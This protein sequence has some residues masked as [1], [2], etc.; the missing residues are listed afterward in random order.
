MADTPKRVI[1][2]IDNIKLELYEGS[3]KKY[4]QIWDPTGNN[5]YN[6]GDGGPSGIKS[7]ERSKKYQ[8]AE[9]D[10]DIIHNFI[11][12]YSQIVGYYYGKSNRSAR[13][14]YFNY[15]QDPFSETPPPKRIY[16]GGGLGTPELDNVGPTPYYLNN[17][18][19]V[20][21]KWTGRV[22]NPEFKLGTFS[23][24]DEAEDYNQSL[25]PEGPPRWLYDQPILSDMDETD[26]TENPTLRPQSEWILK[27]YYN[28]G[29]NVTPGKTYSDYRDKPFVNDKFVSVTLPTGF[30]EN[31]GKGYL[32]WIGSGEGKGL[33]YSTVPKG[34][35]SYVTAINGRGEGITEESNNSV[36]NNF[37]DYYKDEDILKT[38]INGYQGQVSSL[39]KTSMYDYALKVC[40]PDTGT[41]SP[42]PYKSPIVDL[43][44]VG[45]T[46][47]VDVVGAT[48]SLIPKK[49]KLNVFGLPG[50]TSLSGETDGNIKVK[51][52]VSLP[53]FTVYLGDPPGSTG[54][55]A[56]G[57]N[58]FGLIDD[59]VENPDPY[60]E[61]P[62]VGPVDGGERAIP[63][64]TQDEQTND[65]KQQEE[66]A[67]KQN[68]EEATASDTQKLPDG[69]K[70]LGTYYSEFPADS[71]KGGE[72]PSGFNGVPYYQQFDIRWANV[73]YG[74][75]DGGTFV[76]AKI[77]PRL[78]SKAGT[79]KKV[80]VNWDGK[81]H[82]VNCDHKNGDHGYS[83]IH[84]GGC[85]ITSISMIIN[86]WA[87]KGKT[88]GKYTSPVKMAKMA[89]ENGARPKANPGTNGTQPG[90]S[91]FTAVKKHFGLTMKSVTTAQAKKL[92]Q[93]NNPVLFCG[94]N[95]Q[96]KGA[97]KGNSHN[98][99]GHFIA[100]TGC[101]STGRWRVNDPGSTV[102]KPG[103][104]ISYFDKFPG[105]TG[106]IG[107]GSFWAIGP[108][109]VVV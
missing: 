38:I 44:G 28:P 9:D 93:G 12:N 61:S 104:G 78:S 64:I 94:T 75:S 8:S 84:G 71:A 21:I 32:E 86:Y 39:Y 81:T 101:D 10:N 83:D 16:G 54:S 19:K 57:L 49:V 99:E 91:L 69:L 52:K 37:S 63:L 17:G 108:P 51:V 95:F 35:T 40:F 33:V 11:E 5:T 45:V 80:S 13:K 2:L 50:V 42:I 53:E 27:T 47:S 77:L 72:V 107:K 48:P 106:F 79:N 23:T 26:S 76:E 98:Y 15:L 68:E 82:V 58:P 22:P 36:K 62:F 41:C 31:N 18:C 66:I 24:P 96:G 55:D 1:R 85:G 7:P 102:T 73:I 43:S 3:R 56:T 60:E 25:N 109:D 65:Q 46:P 30:T 74:P 100:F 67:K 59:E 14:E 92:I 70:S 88:G 87:K 4:V 20:N 6:E 90:G 29:N 89:S 97:D 103:G 105:E 34:T